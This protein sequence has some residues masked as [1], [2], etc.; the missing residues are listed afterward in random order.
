MKNYLFAPFKDDDDKIKE[1]NAVVNALKYVLADVC[2]TLTDEDKNH[3]MESAIHGLR[4][5]IGRLESYYDATI[6][7]LKAENEELKADNKRIRNTLVENASMYDK[8]Q[9]E[10]QSVNDDY[11]NDHK[12]HNEYEDGLLAEIKELKAEL[13]T[14]NDGINDLNDVLKDLQ[15]ES[16][17]QIKDNKRLNDK[18]GLYDEVKEL[19]AEN[20]R[21]M[22][23]VN[24]KWTNN[25]NV[26]TISGEI[27]EYMSHN[28]KCG[29]A[30]LFLIP[31][32]AFNDGE[33]DHTIFWDDGIE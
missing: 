30:R 6:C 14:A 28:D 20:E 25:S 33:Y 22:K 17:E 13:V 31:H 2:P 12:V 21:L 10:L 5:F 23:Q 26:H 32:D 27:A 16:I 7:H 19:Q 3:Y 11:N 15:A 18:D 9:A 24:S 1:F 4:V 8:L 29:G